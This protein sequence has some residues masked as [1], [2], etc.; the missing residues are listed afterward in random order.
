MALELDGDTTLSQFEKE[1]TDPIPKPMRIQKPR[2]KKVV[3]HLEASEDP[4]I[5][6]SA[7]PIEDVV[8]MTQPPQQRGKRVVQNTPCFVGVSFLILA[9]C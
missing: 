3:P 6:M 8:L 1:N 4:L 5:T 7:D 9:H 2:A